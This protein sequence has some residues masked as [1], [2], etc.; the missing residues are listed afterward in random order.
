MNLKER[1]I[2]VVGAAGSIGREVCVRLL[3]EGATV[4]AADRS[5][6]ALSGLTD[7]YEKTCSVTTVD[8]ADLAAVDQMVE[9]TEAEHGPVQGLV[10]VA[11]WFE[12]ADFADSAPAAWDTMLRANLL[13]A[14]V[15]CRV[16]VPRMVQRGEGSIVNFASTAGEYGS[17]RPSAAYAAAKGGVIAFTKSLAREVSPHGVRV[18]A[19]SPGPVETPMLGVGS[20]GARA[21]AAARTL[22][23]R[24]GTPA[25]IAAGVTYLVS[26]DAS[27]VTGE[28]LRI[29]GGSLL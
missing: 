20:E 26:D 28:V 25:D 7:E 24:L 12:I 13:T 2:L 16:L 29:N 27:W 19:V 23:R 8:G 6:D 4:V 18:N 11:G 22:L 21:E 17:I 3:A 14:M 1:T 10:N 5:V 9:Q 15:S